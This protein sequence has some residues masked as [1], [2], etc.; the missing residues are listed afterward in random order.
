MYMD[1]L[2]PHQTLYSLDVGVFCLF[3]F[4]SAAAGTDSL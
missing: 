1:D 4:T 2:L 3:L